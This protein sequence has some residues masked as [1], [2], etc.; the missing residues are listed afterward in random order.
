MKL[1]QSKEIRIIL[2]YCEGAYSLHQN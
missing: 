2:N 1:M